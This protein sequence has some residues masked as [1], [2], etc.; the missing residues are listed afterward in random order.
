MAAAA[1]AVGVVTAVAGM[2][3]RNAQVSQQRHQ[4]QL[5]ME[6]NS[7]AARIQTLEIE[8]Q[9]AQNRFAADLEKQQTIAQTQLS[10]LQLQMNEI[11]ERVNIAQQ[12]GAVNFDDAQA[13]IIAAAQQYE[14]VRAS[15]EQEQATREESLN[16]TVEA[17]TQYAQMAQ[18]NQQL[19][20][21]LSQGDIR[22]AQLLSSTLAKSDPALGQSSALRNLQANQQMELESQIQTEV[23]ANQAQADYIESDLQRATAF[24]ALLA[25]IQENQRVNQLVAS[26]ILSAD[27]A[28]RAATARENLYDYGQ[29][30]ASIASLGQ[31][32][33]GLAEQIGLLQTDINLGY[34][35]DSLRNAAF[36][37]KAQYG[38]QNDQIRASMP[39]R[40]IFGGLLNVGLAAMPLVSMGIASRNQPVSPRLGTTATR[41]NWTSLEQ[42][43]PY[44]G[45]GQ[46]AGFAANGLTN[47]TLRGG[48]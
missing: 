25:K 47:V 16:R 14:A 7:R 41:Y 21:A 8:R 13:Q 46:M 33:V 12:L 11:A 2:A 37:V 15:Y 44:F 34:S 18:Q 31:Q 4:A 43:G 19:R 1:P 27:T 36:G 29:S 23:L 17:G 22:R 10:R 32:G 5:Q 35:E 45:F 28:A 9:M 24:D 6:A 39:R 26:N 20:Q 30:V 3:Q 38:S 48:L 40:N 42:P